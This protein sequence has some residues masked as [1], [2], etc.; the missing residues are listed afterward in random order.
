MPR[1]LDPFRL[2]LLAGAGW[3][4]QR[5]LKIVDYLRENNRFLR[6]QLGGR[7]MRLND[8]QRRRLTAKA[9]GLGRKLP[10]EMATILTLETLPAWHRKP[11]AEKYDGCNKRSPGRPRTAGE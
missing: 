8:H 2:V 5:Q 3:M 7:R 1:V 10:G 6:E 4:N 9:R 11:I